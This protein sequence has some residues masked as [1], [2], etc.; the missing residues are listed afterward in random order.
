[1]SKDVFHLSNDSEDVEVL[2]EVRAEEQGLGDDDELG[3]A[4]VVSPINRINVLRVK[5]LLKRM[6]KSSTTKVVKGDQK[7][8]PSAYEFIDSNEDDVIV[9]DFLRGKSVSKL[10]LTDKLSKSKDNRKNQ[11]RIN[12]KNKLA[13]ADREKALQ[14]EIDHLK[15]ELAPEEKQIDEWAPQ[16]DLSCAKL[17]HVLPMC[18]KHVETCSD[19]SSPWKDY[20]DKYEQ[21]ESEE[22]GE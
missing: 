7:A 19:I 6:G 17:K 9:V 3:N 15:D 5:E 1:M 11:L 13:A 22:D 4:E 16:V 14:K 20:C 10:E 18:E 21:S 12:T 2:G 8:E